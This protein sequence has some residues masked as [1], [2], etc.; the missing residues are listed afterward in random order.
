MF[1]GLG[2]LASMMKQASQMQGLMSDAQEKL[3]RVRVSGTAGGGMVIVE[4]TGQQKVVSCQI[5]E[6]LMKTGDRELIED[7]VTAATNQA[8]EKSREAAAEEMNRL[9]GGLNLPGLSE[10]LANFQEGGG[11][12]SGPSPTRETS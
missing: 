4:A 12:S 8:L 11:P 2:N 1:N 7:L 9:A 6:S 10:A 5:D 3:A